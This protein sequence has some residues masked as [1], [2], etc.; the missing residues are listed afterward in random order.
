MKKIPRDANWH[1]LKWLGIFV[2]SI[3]LIGI[4]IN[5]D[6]SMSVLSII[7]TAIAPI[8]LGIF[9]A[10]ILNV[11]VNIF[12]KKVFK[13]LTQRNGRIWSKI[14][15]AVSISLSLTL[16]FLIT[17]IIL[18]YII[19]EFTKTCESFIDEAP[20]YMDQ[21][22]NTLREWAVKLHLPISP[23]HINFSWESITAWV[24]TFIGNNSN[25]VFHNV[26]N[27]AITIFTSIWNVCIGLVL[28]VYIVASKESIVKMFKG[29]VFS[30]STKE[31]A[32][33][34][35]S[36]L[37]LTK[38]AFEDFIS[39]QC[40]DVVCIGSL[41]FVGMLIFQFPHPAMISCIIAITAFVPIFGAII[42][43][44]VGALIILLISPI[45]ALWFLVFIIVLQQIESNVIYPK[46][47]GQQIGLPSLWVLIAVML[48]GGLFGIT[49]ILLFVPLC[50][51]CYALFTQWILKRLREKKLCKQNATA[52]PSNITQLS[53]DE[54]L[55]PESDSEPIEKKEK[56]QKNKK[57]KNKK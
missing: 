48:G 18:F 12:E 24:A 57:G 31:K 51:V 1:Y 54:F 29:F 37:H 2:V 26:L 13:K 28:A 47:M 35:F 11:P 46:I 9:I 16:F 49:G 30:V 17:T 8:L 3:L 34:V 32:N 6:T 45:K 33:N 36:V 4:V 53:D 19:P 40:L 52:I 44:I 56:K 23:D 41:T 38:K 7:F 43:A 10:V 25:D 50:S 42:G 27:T 15:R 22:T 5:F 20:S 39:G 21:F 14:K 55:S